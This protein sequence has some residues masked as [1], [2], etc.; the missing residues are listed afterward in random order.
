MNRIP[1]VVDVQTRPPHVLIVG[2]DDGQ[3]REIDMKD[4][5]WGTMFEPL[6]DPDFFA[7]VCVDEELGTVVWPNGLDLAPE[8]LYDP[9]LRESREAEMSKTE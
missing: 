5:L 2:F 9:S 4:E 1:R 7:Q 3:V 8:T 6:Q